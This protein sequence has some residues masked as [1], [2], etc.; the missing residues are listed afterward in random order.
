M[1][2]Q[3]YH[4]FSVFFKMVA[5]GH[6]GSLNSGNL[7]GQRRPESRDVSPYETSSLN[8]LKLPDISNFVHWLAMWSISL[9]NEK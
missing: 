2:H 1:H 7:N 6:L 5:L 9:W 4:Y 8:W 3:R